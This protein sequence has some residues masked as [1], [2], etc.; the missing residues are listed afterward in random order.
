MGAVTGGTKLVSIVIPSYNREK[1]IEEA[2]DCLKNQTYKD[3]EV[4]VI[5]D[6]SSDNTGV[7]VKTWDF[8]NQNAFRQLIYLK[9]PRNCDEEW[10]YNTGFSLA[11]GEY[12]GIQNSDDLCHEERIQIQEEYLSTHPEVAVAGCGY[13]AFY[14][15]P[16]DFFYVADWLCFDSQKIMENYTKKLVHC[17]CTGTLLFRP[18]VIKKVIGFK[19]VAF[20]V[21]DVCFVKDIVDCGFTI[22]NSKENLYYVRSHPDQKSKFLND[23]D[24]IAEK[25]KRTK[26]RVSVV[27]PVHKQ[28][29]SMVASLESIAEQSYDNME[30]IVVD[31]SPDDTAEAIIR[32]WYQRYMEA[33]KHPNI[34]ELVYL[35]LPKAIRDYWLYN[36]G[37]YI[38]KGEYI[39]YQGLKGISKK[40]RIKKQVVFFKN[41]PDFCASGTNFKKNNG[42]IKFNKDVSSSYLQKYIPCLYVDTMMLHY[43]V[44][45]KT[46]GFN[47]YADVDPGFE[48]V[49]RL[50]DKKYRIKNLKNIL[51]IEA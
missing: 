20:G 49:H 24:Y 21:N 42:G 19:K 43:S 50:L 14:E 15:N 37:A 4:I 30:L 26:G 33:N 40:N 29:E 41:H 32:D 6:G 34:K 27:C 1:Y 46:A 7:V 36:I 9:L 39:A 45:D 23:K 44:I 25:T 35:K 10:A 2:L 16:D 28:T 48:F 31:D 51:Y 18:E 12:T 38:S 5:D 47:P 22:Y 3:I 17:V 8:R 11:G 13:K